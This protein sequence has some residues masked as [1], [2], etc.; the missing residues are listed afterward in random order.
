MYLFQKLNYNTKY[1][2]VT[3]KDE[4]IIELKKFF[5]KAVQENTKYFAF[6]TETTGLNIITDKAFLLV[7]GFNKD[8]LIM[9]FDPEIVKI[10][11]K[12]YEFCKF[13]E[14]QDFIGAFAHNCKFDYHMCWN[15]GAKIPEIINVCDSMTTARLTEFADENASISLETLGVKYVDSKSKF[16]GKIIQDSIKKINA[17]RRRELK[18]KIMNN[19]PND[20]YFTITRDNKKRGTSKLTN[21]LDEFIK[22]VPYV[23]ADEPIFKFI[24]ENYKEA[25][26]EDVYKLEPE[27]MRCYAADDVVILLEY[28]NKSIPA[29]RQVDTDLRV[30]K[31]ES[32]LIPIVADYEKNGLKVNID[33]LLESRKRLVEYRELLYFEL[34]IYSG[35]SFSVGQHSFIKNLLL[36]KYGV[37]TDKCDD[38]A[39]KYIKNNGKGEVIDLVSNIIELRTIDK[40]LSTYVDGKLKSMINGRIYT[41]INLNGAVSGR[42]SCDMQQ[43]PKD[44]LLDRD[45]NE[46]FHPRKMFVT[47]EGYKL[48]FID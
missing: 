48:F 41:S 27:L 43:Q 6:D 16:A 3:K 26:Y 11:W 31:R 5:F 21:V 13:N 15:T 7:I 36:K 4:C 20:G 10:V 29:I 9:D 25:T 28:L 44:P 12:I 14:N 46:L 23:N 35:E 8:I 1:L 39:L 18:E 30:T 32:E 40:W 19:F 17:N 37:R 33:Y 24:E 34:M 38:K 22:R 47:D 2:D 45:G 42:V